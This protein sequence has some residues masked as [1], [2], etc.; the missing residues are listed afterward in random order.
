MPGT[1]LEEVRLDDF[2]PA[3]R[4]R[5]RDPSVTA[6][7]GEGDDAQRALRVLLPTDEPVEPKQERAWGRVLIVPAQA[8]V[9]LVNG[10][11]YTRPVRW[12]VVSE[13]AAYRGPGYDV[14]RQAAANQRAVWRRLRDWTP[15]LAWAQQASPIRMDRPPQD[16]VL[17]DPGTRL[18]Y[19]SSE[20][21]MLVAARSAAA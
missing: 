12:L 13:F 7:L 11:D 5:L 9:S 6:S 15:E 3:L 8:P 18:W 1:G 14:G 2:W 21:V 19:L 20:Y 4:A 16:L 17:R 10:P